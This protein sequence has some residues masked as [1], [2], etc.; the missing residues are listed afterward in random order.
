MIYKT[1]IPYIGDWDG[2]LLA[3]FVC[4]FEFV[5][6]LQ[7]VLCVP[8]KLLRCIVG[9]AGD[10]FPLAGQARMPKALEMG[11]CLYGEHLQHHI[12]ATTPYLFIWGAPTTPHWRYNTI[13]VYS[14]STYNTVP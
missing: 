13:S 12:C 3:C 7:C 4:L 14:G 1:Y 11:R 2:L 5:F 6:V 9:G 8:V 10:D